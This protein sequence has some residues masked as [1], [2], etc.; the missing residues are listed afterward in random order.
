[1]DPG[2]LS[3]SEWASIGNAIKLLWLCLLLMITASTT[4]VLAHAVIPSAVAT[5]TISD[6][7]SKLRLGLY[8]TGVLAITSFFVSLVFVYLELYPVLDNLWPRWF[9]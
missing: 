6:R 3:T 8:A 4:L 5:R 9:S 7:W 1:M 2:L